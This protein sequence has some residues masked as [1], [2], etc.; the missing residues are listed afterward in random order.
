[1][2]YLISQSII[3]LLVSGWFCRI[4][5][6]EITLNADD[7]Q[8]KEVITVKLYDNSEG[9][10]LLNLPLTFHLNK[11]NILFMIVGDENELGRNAAVWMF[12]K[13]LDLNSF[14]KL[15]KNT[16]ATKTFKKQT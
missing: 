4:S 16:G 14:L 12:D 13:T 7:K 2:N 15:N 3:V 8:N 10:F 1:M 9:G 11:D 5:A 6:Q